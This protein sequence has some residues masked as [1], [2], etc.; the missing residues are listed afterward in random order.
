M[1]YADWPVY[2]AILKRDNLACVYCGLD[3][4]ANFA[5]WCQLLNGVDHLVPGHTSEAA[6]YVISYENM[7]NLVTCCWSCN[8]AKGGFNPLEAAPVDVA[9]R[10]I[11]TAEGWRAE[12]I[13][14]VQVYLERVH[15][16]YY[17]PDHAQMRTELGM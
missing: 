10:T 1:A 4:K 11:T 2:W 16:S 8:R 3:G 15:W 12:L 6:S 5:S 17:R 14:R 7:P 9:E 13:K